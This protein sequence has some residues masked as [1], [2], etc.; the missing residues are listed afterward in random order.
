M[1]GRKKSTKKSTPI[2]TGKKGRPILGTPDWKPVFLKHISEGLHVRDACK[3]AKVDHVMP[4]RERDNNEAF[5]IAWE[6]AGK[7][8]TKAL[9]SEAARRAYHGTLKPVYQ[10]G[11]R[12]GQIREYSDTLLMF[13]L[14]GR[15]PK[16]YRD[17]VNVKHSGSTAVK[18]QF[19]E[20][21]IDPDH[22][23]A[24]EAPQSSA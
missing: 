21:V 12:V 17:N 10:K 13:L 15:K 23:P 3:L 4:Y 11:M 24:D 14:K 16:K 6:E 5:R 7:I 9:E 22:P 8:G 18:L 1:A 2:R 20:E 19:V